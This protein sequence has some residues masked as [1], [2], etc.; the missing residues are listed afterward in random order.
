M[1]TNGMKAP[2]IEMLRLSSGQLE[3]LSDHAGEIIVLEFW[4]TWC[5][6]CEPKVADLQT[7][8]GKNPG[9]KGKVVL[10]AASI[11][12]VPD[13]ATKRLKAKGWEN[14]HNVWVGPNANRPTSWRQSPRHMLLT[15]KVRL[16]LRTQPTFPRS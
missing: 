10:I 14:T 1:L 6:P 15:G 11:D 5:G 13:R 12:D 8:L 2:D 3:R 9:W 16:S 4:G 7:Y